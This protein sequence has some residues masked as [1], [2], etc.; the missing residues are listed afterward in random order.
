[1]NKNESGFSL[2]EL[3]IVIAIISILSAIAVPNFLA[4][5]ESAKLRGAAFNLKSDMELAKMRAIRYGGNVVISF[6]STGYEIY[7][8]TNQDYSKNGETMVASKTL[9]GVTV[10]ANFDDQASTAFNSRGQVIRL[11]ATEAKRTVTLT[12]RNDS[13]KIIVNKLGLIIIK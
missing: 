13:I 6:S 12:G 9:E 1:M 5:R 11:G 10:S 7:Q 3:M 2:F 4:Y 8:D